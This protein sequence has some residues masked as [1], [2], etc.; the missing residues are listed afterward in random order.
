MERRRPAAVGMPLL[1]RG[2]RVSRRSSRAG[3][4]SAVPGEATLSIGGT[5][6]EWNR[7]AHAL[8]R[9]HPYATHIEK[10]SEYGRPHLLKSPR[11]L[12]YA[13]RGRGGVS[14]AA[15]GADCKSAVY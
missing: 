15:K 6:H 2:L 3:G 10:T 9:V 12:K 8:V 7:R 1:S 4:M 11:C 14:R 13:R 5:D